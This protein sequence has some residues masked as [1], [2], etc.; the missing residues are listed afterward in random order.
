MVYIKSDPSQILLL[1]TNL[2]DIIPKDHIC[3]LIEEVVQEL[4]FSDFDKE[5]E[6]PGNPTY[7]PRIIIKI[8]LNGI[9]DRITSTRKLE[10]LTIENIVFRYLSENLSPD[11]HTIAMF[12]KDNHTLIKKCFLQTI[13]IAKRLDMVNLNKL[14]LD[15]IKVKANASKSKTFTKEEIDFLSDFVDKQFE[16]TEIVDKEED[17]RYGESDGEIKIPEQ[18]THKKKLQ[19]KVKEM[20]KDMGMA[21]KQMKQAKDKIEKEDAKEVNLTDMD[22]KMMKM[23]KG[24]HY[25]QA[26]N[27]QLLVEDKGE[28]IVG[29]NL[30]DS[31]TDI[32]ET[33]PTMEK[34]KKEQKASLKDVEVFQDNGY[35][36]SAT[37]EYYEKEEAIAYIPDPVTTKELH[38]K[39]Y[40]ITKFNSDNFQ[41][42]FEKNQAICPAGHR[43]DFARKEI[44]KKTKSWT[45]IYKT[46]ECKN[47]EFRKECILNK[48][49]AY[50][51]VA[52][53][54]LMRKIRLRFKTKEGIEKYNKRFHKGEI[55]Q[56]HIEHNLGYREFKCR[57]NKVCENEVNLFSTVYNLI[58]IYKKWKENGRRLIPSLLKILF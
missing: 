36:C 57:G 23:K 11:F 1:P 40:E 55:A 17:K 47:C 24:I 4:D 15:G 42:D 7:H 6:G 21:Q 12:R 48:G 13:K 54:P 29:N 31:A 53:N 49:A 30:S 37:A 25:E 26:Y 27:C 34:F 58:K 22:S 46:K 52:I 18:L 8:I 38:G 35:S 28:I 9:C 10:K 33:E 50:R 16:E 32:Y 19:E 14:Y 41:L 2:R 43:M 39:T 45:N 44:D 20:M 3:F 51:Y 56:A 5:V